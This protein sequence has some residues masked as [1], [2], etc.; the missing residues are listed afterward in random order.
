MAFVLD[1]QRLVIPVNFDA[2]MAGVK[3][4]V[5][6]V[7]S[8]PTDDFCLSFDKSQLD[9]DMTLT[10]LEVTLDDEIDIVR[11]APVAVRDLPPAPAAVSPLREL[12]VILLLG[13][14]PRNTTIKIEATKTLGD[15]LPLAAAKFGAEDLALEFVSGDPGEENWSFLP[16]STPIADAPDKNAAD[17]LC[18]REASATFPEADLQAG[19]FDT[20]STSV[21][22]S[23]APAPAAA[24]DAEP[25]AEA[26]AELGI[27]YRFDIPERG[28]RTFYF[29]ATA[30]VGDARR[31]IAQEYQLPSEDL[32]TLIFI[33]KALKDTFLLNR[34]RI[35]EGVI[36]VCIRDNQAVLLLTARALQ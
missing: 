36:T 11:T 15:L 35:G 8:V 25:E 23:A 29:E 5:S 33:G 26:E 6:V 20:L 31:R 34:L 4:S 22:R 24:A 14:I 17:C 9:D 32:V 3:E 30:K 28:V 18:L 2:P 21:R 1:S 27:P 7:I 19:L 16:L 12:R 10:D 13:V